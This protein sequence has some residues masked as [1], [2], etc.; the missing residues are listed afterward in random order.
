MSRIQRFFRFLLPRSLF[1]AIEA[2]SRD[3]KVRCN[4]CR[5]A[6]SVWELGGIR[7]GGAGN[8]RIRRRCPNCGKTAWHRFVRESEEKF[9]HVE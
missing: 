5:F 3:W 2:E 6:P 4:E 9:F 7:Y 1:A 8:P